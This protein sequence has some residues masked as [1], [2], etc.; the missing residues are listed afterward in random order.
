[1]NGIDLT[2]ATDAAY[3]GYR[4]AMKGAPM[5]PGEHEAL[6]SR[7]EFA[8]MTAALAAAAPLIEAQVRARVAAEIEA[9]GHE[10]WCCAFPPDDN[11]CPCGLDDHARIARGES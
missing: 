10:P 2:E 5:E 9:A 7:V 4:T 8:W 3:R 6:F 1:V 11:P